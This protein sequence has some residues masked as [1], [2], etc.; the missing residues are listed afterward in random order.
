MGD[1]NHLKGKKAVIIGASGLVGRNCF[2]FFSRRGVMV[3]GTHLSDK[4]DKLIKLDLLD[5]NQVDSFLNENKFDIVVVPASN[6]S[7]EWCELNP[8]LAYE[9]NVKATNHVVDICKEKNSKMLFFS[10][11]YIFDG[12]NGPYTENDAP[13]P[14]S[15]YGSHKLEVERYIQENLTDYLILRTTVVFGNEKKR[16]NFAYKILDNLTKGSPVKVP[17]DQISSPTYAYSLAETAYLLL[18]NNSRGIF[19]LVG[20]DII[21]RYDFSR[22]IADVFSLNKDLLIPVKTNELNQ[23]AKRPLKVG[24]INKKLCREINYNFLP[25]KKEVERFRLESIKHG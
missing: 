24:L 22:M 11:E 6:P 25:I 19:N 7:V 1:K 23:K 5:L 14:I 12:K 10:S 20:N 18:K 13:N 2:D 3:V 16:K 17:I 15:V 9:L 8:K 4:Q 21:S